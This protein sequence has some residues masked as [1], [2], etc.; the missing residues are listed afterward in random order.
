MSKLL[1]TKIGLAMFG[2][3]MAL[4][5]FMPNG[6]VAHAAP[7][8]KLAISYEIAG[9]VTPKAGGSYTVKP[10]LTDKNL[11][12]QASPALTPVTFITQS[13]SD[14]LIYDTFIL[15]ASVFS[16]MLSIIAMGA[17]IGLGFRIAREVRG[18]LTG[19]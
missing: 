19:A 17:G 5:L 1:V 12:V 9:P 8:A 10:N 11:L 2:L 15:A 3:L 13:Q 7:P 6:N 18:F 14:E 16:S 4:G